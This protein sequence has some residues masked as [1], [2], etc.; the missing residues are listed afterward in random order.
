M[1]FLKASQP[2]FS[3]HFQH[4]ALPTLF[5]S[6]HTNIQNAWTQFLGGQRS[7]DHL[8]KQPFLWLCHAHPIIH[9]PLVHV[10]WGLQAS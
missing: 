3:S 9:R 7:T 10:G 6:D 8:S 5:T 1:A 4:Q 2:P